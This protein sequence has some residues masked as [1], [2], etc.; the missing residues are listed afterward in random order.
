M[1]RKRGQRRPRPVYR[2][3]LELA[4]N[5]CTKLTCKELWSIVVPLRTAFERMRQGCASTGD[6]CVLAGFLAL[7]Q[8]IER[9]GALRGSLHGHLTQAD[10]AL[11]AVEARATASGTWRAP[12]LYFSE[13]DAIGTFVELHE[14]QL[15]QLSY[16]EYR[17]VYARTEGQLRSR[18]VAVE[19]LRVQ[20]D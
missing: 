17:R 2:N 7:A 19:K 15:E 3:T 9:S 16:A 11:V 12:A 20:Q 13:M 5:Q 18:G 1:S 6:W 14:F 4:R 8:T 10:A